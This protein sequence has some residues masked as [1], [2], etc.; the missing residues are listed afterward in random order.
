M[1]IKRLV[2]SSVAVVTAVA[3]LSLVTTSPAAAATGVWRA[4]GN[5]NPFDFSD[6]RWLCAVSQPV[7]ANGDVL[8]Q[9]CV[10][11][12][13]PDENYVQGAVIVRNNRPSLYGASANVDLSNVLG[14]LDRW[15]CPSSGVAKNTWSVCFGKTIYTSNSLTARGDANGV[16]L[17][18]T[19]PF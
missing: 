17:G 5:K 6:S 15:T 2:A 16:S 14:F 19:R 8:A 13:W 18:V 12:G 10:V 4:L 9:V 11:R 7:T 3:G 1:K